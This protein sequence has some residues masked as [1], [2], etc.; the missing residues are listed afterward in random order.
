[1]RV[2]PKERAPCGALSSGYQRW[3]NR[4]ASRLG[5]AKKPAALAASPP[6]WLGGSLQVSG[7]RPYPLV[8]PLPVQSSLKS[9]H[10][11]SAVVQLYG[12]GQD[13]GQLE[14]SVERD[15]DAD[16]RRVLL[17]CQRVGAE[18]VDVREH[19]V[20]DEQRPRID[21]VAREP[22]EGV[23]VVLLRVDEDDVECLR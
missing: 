1:A 2:H 9:D 10:L 5:V 19:V 23:V 14:A 20:G 21:L 4:G 7:T 8:P 11:L 17:P 16:E 13:G 12:S 15:G 6:R 18:G 3:I 22:E